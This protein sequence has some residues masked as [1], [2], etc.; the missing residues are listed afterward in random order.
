MIRVC[1]PDVVAARCA[2]LPKIIFGHVAY[3]TAANFISGWSGNNLWSGQNNRFQKGFRS[4]ARARDENRTS[5]NTRTISVCHAHACF[6]RLWC[7]C[8]MGEN[9]YVRR[10]AFS[11]QVESKKFGRGD[12]RYGRARQLLDSNPTATTTVRRRN[13]RALFA[14]W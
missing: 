1:C 8:V 12:G 3:N 10:D 4:S 2:G 11:L 14:V 6:R 7:R 5:P 13:S 9:Q